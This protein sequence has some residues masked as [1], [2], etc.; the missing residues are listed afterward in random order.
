[1]RRGRETPLVEYREA[2]Y[3]NQQAFVNTKFVVSLA[4]LGTGRAIRPALRFG[5]LNQR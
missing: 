3:R 5:L 4:R 2:E 1:M